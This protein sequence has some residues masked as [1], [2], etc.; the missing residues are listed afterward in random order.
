MIK[1][2]V[3]SQALRSEHQMRTLTVVVQVWEL[4]TDVAM[5]DVVISANNVPAHGRA[6]PA[7][8][9]GFVFV[10]SGHRTPETV[11]QRDCGRGRPNMRFHIAS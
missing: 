10:H 5:A 2:A 7:T 3:H 9:A 4:T 1:A 8:S 11:S 6:D